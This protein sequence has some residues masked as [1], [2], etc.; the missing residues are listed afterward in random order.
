M[1][2]ACRV[3]EIEDRDIAILHVEG[4]LDFPVRAQFQKD[5]D[6]LRQTGRPKLVVDIGRIRRMSSLYIGSLIDFGHSVRQE[7]RTFSVML[8]ARLVEV[9]REVGLDSAASIIPIGE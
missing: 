4:E 7:Q 8:S 1:T 3:E 9:C 5:L 6:R 2:L